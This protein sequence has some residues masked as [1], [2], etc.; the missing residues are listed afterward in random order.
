MALYLKAKPTT[1]YLH[2]EEELPVSEDD[3]FLRRVLNNIVAVEMWNKRMFQQP[4]F[5]G[6]EKGLFMDGIKRFRNK[7][8]V[9]SLL[10]CL[11]H[12]HAKK[13]NICSVKSKPLHVFK[14]QG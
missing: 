6:S 2:S 9:N 12:C 13:V 5:Q 11:S 14:R 7:E 10:A 4:D 3:T 1:P 8:Q